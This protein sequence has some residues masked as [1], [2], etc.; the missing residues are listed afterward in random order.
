MY[1][2]IVRLYSAN[3][4]LKV[5]AETLAEFEKRYGDAPEYAEVALKL[6]DCYIA[7]GR[8][9]DERAVY[10]RI[11]DYLGEHNPKGVPLVESSSQASQSTDSENK[12]ALDAR[13]EPTTVKP[14][15]AYYPPISNPG[16]NYPGASTDSDTAYYS[17][18]SYPDYL[19]SVQLDSDE[20]DAQVITVDYQTVLSRYVASLAK[21]NRTADIL[22][23]YSAELKKYP[24]EEG[25]CEQMLQWLGQTNL[26]DE[27]L[28]VYQAAVR[29]FPSTTW[30][31]RLAR[32]FIRQKRTAEF[33][34]FSRELLAKVNDAEAE[35]YLQ[36]FIQGNKNA[37]PVTFDA[38]LYVALYSLAHERF[39][40]N[41]HFVSGLLQYYSAHKQWEPWRMLV[42][43]YYFESRDVR[44]GDA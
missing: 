34:A 10:Q 16:I 18:Y 27:Q 7:V 41:L 23:L 22:A 1:L 14:I 25:L 13:S 21:D 28:R 26:V 5:A 15:T 12:P 4:D 37:D 35:R 8:F 17:G 6:A 43:E 38:K 11:L 24:D 3:K 31:D 29:T 33:E 9:H 19:E 36:E 32:W 20:S 39:P 30:H 40:H 44:V 42:A 2:D